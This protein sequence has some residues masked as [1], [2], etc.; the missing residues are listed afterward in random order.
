MRLKSVVCEFESHRGYLN[1]SVV[2]LVDT[3]VLSTHAEWR[4]GSNPFRG[5]DTKQVE[6]FCKRNDIV[7]YQCEWF[8]EKGEKKWTII[9][10]NKPKTWTWVETDIKF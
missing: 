9:T 8:P 10:K 6:G 7:H 2:E 4:E 3:W 1:A 5:T